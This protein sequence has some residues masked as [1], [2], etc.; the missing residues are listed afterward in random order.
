MKKVNLKVIEELK[1]DFFIEI[2]DGDNK[3]ELTYTCLLTFKDL[4]EKHGHQLA[5]KKYEQN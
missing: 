2:S 4:L 3:V 5:L 1:D